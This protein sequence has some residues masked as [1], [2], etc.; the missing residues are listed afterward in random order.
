MPSSFRIQ[1]LIF[2]MED[3]RIQISFS[4]P[5]A[6]PLQLNTGAFEVIISW[7]LWG[8]GVHRESPS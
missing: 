8:E 2:Q 3:F 7:L 6:Q 5:R 1:L 4:L